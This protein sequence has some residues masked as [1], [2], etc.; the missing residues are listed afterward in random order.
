MAVF[1]Q[2]NKRARKLSVTEVQEIRKLYAEGY[3]TQGQLSREFSVSVIQIG[4]IVRGEVWQDIPVAA[5]T[6]SPGE[7]KDVMDRALALQKSLIAEGK[8]PPSPLDG[9]DAPG[10][11]EGAVAKLQQDAKRPHELVDGVIKE[12]SNE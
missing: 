6:L 4:R 5:E 10:T 9:G 7:L 8:I 11:V 3:K 1:Q 2:G 12:L